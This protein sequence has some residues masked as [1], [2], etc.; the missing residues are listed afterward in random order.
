[1]YKKLVVANWKMNGVS[2]DIGSMLTAMQKD[3]AI[4][5]RV[6][7]SLCVPAVF[8]GGMRSICAHLPISWGAQNVCD[9]LEGAF[10]GEISGQMLCDVGC[11]YVIVGHSERRRYYGENNY[12]VALKWAAARKAGLTPILCVGESQEEY[13][14]NKTLE[15]IKEQL[16]AVFKITTAEDFAHTV[17]AYEPVWAIGTGLTP[18]IDAVARV[19]TALRDHLVKQYDS[20]TS[21]TVRLLYGGSVKGDNAAQLLTLTNVDGGLIGG[22]SLK[23]DTFSP[24]Y[25][26]LI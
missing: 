14:G 23:Y 15:V 18:S 25:K 26:A 20:T 16:D 13:E 6:D 24:I 22:A 19:H 11:R 10:T 5:N 3:S 8:L 9:E 21:Q 1:M 7:V 4:L 17:I 2:A 12:W